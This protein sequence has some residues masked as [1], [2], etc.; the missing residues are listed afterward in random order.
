MVCVLLKEHLESL[1]N[2]PEGYRALLPP[3]LPT[4]DCFHLREGRGCPSR[5]RC[6]V[7]SALRCSAR[8][9]PRE[10]RADQPCSPVSP[11]SSAP[12]Q[13]IS[14]TD[15]RSRPDALQKSPGVNLTPRS[16]YPMSPQVEY[17]HKRC[18]AP[19]PESPAVA[20]RRAPPPTSLAPASSS[21]RRR[22]FLRATDLSSAGNWS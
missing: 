8:P 15:T 6:A 22:N 20:S 12:A 14:V 19:A 1:W 17:S 10:V 7:S 9:A 4:S 21:A 16:H 13:F 11:P 18:A 5:M 2:L 3:M